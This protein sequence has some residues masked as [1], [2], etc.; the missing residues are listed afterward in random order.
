MSKLYYIPPT[1]ECFDDLKKCATDLWKTID[2]EKIK[3]IKD[4]KNIDDNFMYMWAMFSHNNHEKIISM[5][6]N[7]T[8]H[9][10]YQRLIE[11]QEIKL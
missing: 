3:K 6:K 10:L 11:D 7:D 8:I 1:D 9:A 2:K 5:L 4:I